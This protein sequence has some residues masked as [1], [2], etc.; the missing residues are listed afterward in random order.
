MEYLLETLLSQIY[1]KTFCA[2]VSQLV[3]EKTGEYYE[4]SL[5]K[6]YMQIYPE[7]FNNKNIKEWVGKQTLFGTLR[8]NNED[9]NYLK[10]S[11]V[12]VIEQDILKNSLNNSLPVNVQKRR[13]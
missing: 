11:V 9:H 1:Y 10:A 8:E 12:A 4:D 6:K 13:I 7:S 2:S 5:L 3:S